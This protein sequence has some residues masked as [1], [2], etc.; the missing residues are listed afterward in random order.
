MSII[1]TKRLCIKAVLGWY[2][3]MIFWI[4]F[5]YWDAIFLLLMLPNSG[6]VLCCHSG[7]ASEGVSHK[8]VWVPSTFPA[9][10]DIIGGFILWMH[11]A[12][13]RRRYS[14]TSPL[15]GWAHTQN[16]DAPSQWEATLQ[17]NVATNWLGACTKWLLH[18]DHR[19]QEAH[20]SIW[21]RILLVEVVNQTY[22]DFV[23]MRFPIYP[24]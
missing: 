12:N 17:C 4:D 19:C 22:Y 21:I 14:V 16:G 18:C 5:R 1:G 13:E 2:D 10:K 9:Q 20:F 6:L 8:V 7:G 11:P 15:I 24:N 3:A 23:T